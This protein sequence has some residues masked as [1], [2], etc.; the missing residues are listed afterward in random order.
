MLNWGLYPRDL[1]SHLIGKDAA[2]N[3]HHICYYNKTAAITVTP[4][5]TA[6][7]S[8]YD[9]NAQLYDLRLDV[10]DTDGEGP[11]TTSIYHGNTTDPVY[12]FYVRNY[13]GNYNATIFESNA[14]VTVTTKQGTKTF[15]ISD[16]TGGT[17]ERVW[18]VCDINVLT[19]EVTPVHQIM[20][21]Y[22]VLEN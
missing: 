13:S 8:A 4:V 17:T 11:E 20:D 2:G 21:D 14:T 7:G 3:E 19:G 9:E 1:D 10:D 5:A 15:S 22:D 6:S 12:K 16:T 18:Y